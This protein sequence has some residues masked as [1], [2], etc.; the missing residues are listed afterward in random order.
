MNALL[1]AT[2]LSSSPYRGN[3]FYDE[4]VNGSTKL[5]DDQAQYYGNSNKYWFIYNSSSTQWEMWTTNSDGGGT[6][7]LLLTVDDGTRDMLMYSI[8]LYGVPTSYGAT[9]T[10]TL[11]QYGI[12]GTTATTDATPATTSIHAANA[13]ASAATNTTG[14]NLALSGGAAAS[15][16]ALTAAGLTGDTVTFTVDGFDYVC[17]ENGTTDS[18]HFDCQGETN[19]VCATNLS[20]CVNSQVV[21]WRASAN[22]PT[23][24]TA[25]F[26]RDEKE[27]GTDSF[28]SAWL[29]VSTSDPTNAVITE[30]LRGSLLLASKMALLPPA[31]GKQ[32]TENPALLTTAQTVTIADGSTIAD[33]R[34]WIIKAPVI[35]GVSGG[36]TETVTRATT[37]Y[38]DG[39]PSGSNITISNPYSLWIDAGVSRFDGN[40]VGN[41]GTSPVSFTV[42]QVGTENAVTG[43]DALVVADCGRWTSVTAGIDGNTIVLPDVT[44]T[45]AGCRFTITYTGANGG[46]LLD[47]SPLDS[48]A[49]GIYGSCHNAATI[50]TFSGTDDADIGLVKATS[51]KGDFI[52]LVSDG[53]NG[54][55][56]LGCGGIWTNN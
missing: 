34:N 45:T 9:N 43:A 22:S 56:V 32:T 20:T 12:F 46:A 54:Y 39:A 28:D 19:A 5:G 42:G 30:G 44:A 29:T 21:G 1:L 53:V 52:E 50:T 25:Y 26:S 7:A 47:I 24:G 49:D 18:T 36:G 41:S 4:P 23:S 38:V 15:K 33:W 3:K 13:L 51:I 14:A 11:S 2:L 48:T 37:L 6:D 16:V 17:T 40:V 8:N 31:L 10:L 35:N 55:Y 27:I